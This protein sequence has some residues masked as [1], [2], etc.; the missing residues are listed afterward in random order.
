MH[1]NPY[2]PLN[3]PSFFFASMKFLRGGFFAHS[4]RYEVGFGPKSC[5][6]HGKPTTETLVILKPTENQE[7]ARHF[8]E[9]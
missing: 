8:Q 6:A 2:W 4:P 5:G 9:H 3:G 7:L 1:R